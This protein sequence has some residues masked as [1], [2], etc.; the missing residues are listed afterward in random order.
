MSKIVDN[1]QKL[2]DNFQKKVI[3][4]ES[5]AIKHTASYPT[6]TEINESGDGNLS[7]FTRQLVV[8]DLHKMYVNLI[9]ANNLL[10]A[11]LEETDPEET[12]DM[13]KESKMLVDKMIVQVT[14]IM[15]VMKVK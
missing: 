13:T 10:T 8:M 9:R 7:K 15:N 2:A 12:S 11:S 4:N 3:S 6:M 1:F 14:N 5:E